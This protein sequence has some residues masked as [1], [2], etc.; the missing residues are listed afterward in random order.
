MIHLKNIHF[1]NFD[2]WFLSLDDDNQKQIMERYGGLE[3][4]LGIQ[5]TNEEYDEEKGFEFKIINQDRW[6]QAVLDHDFLNNL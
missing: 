4:Y 5:L 6:A 2:H 3:N 1:I